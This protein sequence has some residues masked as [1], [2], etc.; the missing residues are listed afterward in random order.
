MSAEVWL[1]T[2]ASRGFGR[3][4]ARYA[5]EKG[6]KVAATARKPEAVTAAL[7]E[8]ENLFP[9][10]LDVTKQ[11][12]IDAAVECVIKHFGR[13][14]VLLN[15]AGYGIFGALEEV[16]DAEV[17]ALFDTNFFGAMSLTRTVLPY[18]RAQKSGR[19]VFMGSMASFSCDPGGS[20]YDATKFAVAAM[21]EALSLEMKPFGVESMVVEPG[22]FRTD[23]FDGVSIR[24][25]ERT[26]AAYDNTPARGAMNYCL[27]HNHQQYGDPRKAA[28]LLYDVV[29]SEEPMP[30]W[31]PVG[32]DAV[33]KY[34][35]KFAQMVEAIQPYRDRM[36]DCSF[37]Q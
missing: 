17:R 7:G 1:I 19:L 16:S 34:E 21:S 25:P 3:E 12:Q 26:I 10:A 28:A 29:S 32:R 24:T 33:K 27:S 11:D 5:L 18:M 37:D 6:C 35:R 23:F 8:H 31:L 14:D 2:G 13:I 20:A 9:V 15:N 4:F 30:L 36:R 22:M